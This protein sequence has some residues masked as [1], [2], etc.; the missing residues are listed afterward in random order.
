MANPL[1]CSVAV[2]SIELLFASNWQQ[3]VLNIE[4][5]MTVELEPCRE[6]SIVADVRT[7]GAIGVVELTEAVDSFWIQP[8]LVELG[9]WVRPFGKLVYI[10]PPFIIEP[11]ELAKL[12]S[13][14]CTV[15]GEMNADQTK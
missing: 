2:R 15:V 6:L 11:E 8:R 14:I 4:Q 5:Q 1:A 3:R 9:V 7:K 10:M 12:T 13:A